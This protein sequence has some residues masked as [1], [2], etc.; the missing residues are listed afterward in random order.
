MFPGFWK[1][2]AR[3]VNHTMYMN[4]VWTSLGWVLQIQEGV[5]NLEDTNETKRNRLKK[6][7]D[8]PNVRSL[9]NYQMQGHGSDILRIACLNAVADG[10][11]ISA[12]V[13]D[14]IMILAPKECW[15]EHQSLLVNGMREASRAVLGDA[16][17]IDVDVKNI[18]HGEYYVDDS[19][20]GDE[21]WNIVRSR[22]PKESK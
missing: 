14:A 8:Y 13:H 16:F 9:A 10:L 22:L 2:S 15:E 11:V 21:M 18:K 17:T 1:W 19:G 20:R 7:N 12:T 6:K 4:K 5:L 3:T